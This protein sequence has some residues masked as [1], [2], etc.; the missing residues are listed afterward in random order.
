VKEESKKA[1]KRKKTKLEKI[2]CESD[3]YDEAVKP[4]YT[5]AKTLLSFKKALQKKQ[6]SLL[7]FSGF[8]ARG[9]ALEPRQ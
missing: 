3:F 6:T 9:N 2:S 5:N 8:G 4:V 1:R 7:F